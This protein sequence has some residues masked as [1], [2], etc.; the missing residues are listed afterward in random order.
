MENVTEKRTPWRVVFAKFGMTQAEL[1]R[2]IGC[3]RSKISVALSSD[4]GLI[5][6]RDQIKLMKAARKAGV[7]LKAADLLPVLAR[8]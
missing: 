2:E 6:P 4:E 7:V 3:D 5:N 1:A 8:D